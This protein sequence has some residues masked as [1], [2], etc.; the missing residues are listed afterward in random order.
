MRQGSAY[1]EEVRDFS[2]P[3]AA[4]Q[5]LTCDLVVAGGGLSGLSAAE[6]AMRRGL[7]V[8]VIEKGAFGKEAASGLNAGQFLTGWAKPVDVMLA[9]LT[10]QELRGGASADR[11]EIRAQRRVRAFLR[12]TVEGCLH[13]AEI[14]HRYNLRA[15]VQRGALMAAISEADMASL[16]AAYGFMEK[17]N[18]RALMPAA[19][20]R[21]PPF[22]QVLTARQ[23]QRRY[24]TAEGFYAGGVIDRFGGSFRPRKFLLGFARALQKRGVRFF[25][26][27]DAQ[28]LDVS[29][30]RVHVFCGNGAHIR[31]NTLFMANAYARHINGDALERAIFEYDYV[32]EVELPEGART[33][34]AGSV[35]S[36]TR[37]PC[38]YARR[39]GRRLY[40]GYEETAETS[41]EIMRAVARRTLEEG[42]R[43]FPALADIKEHDIKS[44][45]AGRVYYTLDDYPFVERRHGGRVVTFAAPS[46]HGNSL[47]LRIGA[48]VG[49]VAAQST[50]L[51]RNEGD[52]R[53]RR[54]NAQQLKL[55]ESFPKGL[56]LRPGRRYQEAAFRP[57]VTEEAES[58]NKDEPPG[59]ARG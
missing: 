49:N 27:T 8:V 53:A 51:P 58:D 11:A 29:D 20:K 5:G 32:V 7:D 3:S 18:L 17:S 23:L 19:D 41:P 14:D 50:S 45:W 40:I 59:Q 46:D 12:R 48:L 9:E 2:P 55:F 13:L 21:R 36:D 1:D 26:Q 16:R 31:A 22:F 25:Q 39:H 30:N 6:A 10:Q 54:R 4:N 35:L 15:S 33:L 24:G 42:K 52:V 47:A 37:D 38:F 28:A 56:R 34:A 57:E 43:V 44:A